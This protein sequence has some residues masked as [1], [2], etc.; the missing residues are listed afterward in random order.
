MRPARIAKTKRITI[1]SLR[2]GSACDKPECGG[3]AA[4]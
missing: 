4:P 1:R 3:R 2:G